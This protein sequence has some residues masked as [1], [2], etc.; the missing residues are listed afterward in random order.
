[1]GFGVWD[2]GYGVWGLESGVWGLGSGV[3]GLG[4]G[5]W[6]LESRT[7]HLLLL[8][9]L[10]LLVEGLGI[11]P[12]TSKPNLSIRVVKIDVYDTIRAF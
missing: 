5:V 10:C 3:W 6:G 11:Q 2:L 9:L 7:M 8:L 1:M 4:F 12:P